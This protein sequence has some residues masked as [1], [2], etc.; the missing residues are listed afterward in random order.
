MNSSFYFIP[1]YRLLIFYPLIVYCFHG[2]PIQQNT[3]LYGNSIL[4]VGVLFFLILLNSICQ[5]LNYICVHVWYWL[6]NV[7][8][9]TQIKTPRHDKIC[10]SVAAVIINTKIR[11]S[12]N[13]W[14]TTITTTN[15]NICKIFQWGNWL[16]HFA[17]FRQWLFIVYFNL[18]YCD[19]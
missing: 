12:Y 14:Q 5:I 17:Y 11:N 19:F 16:L 7:Y 4:I 10:P 9:H 2:I 8:R 13:K 3:M 18:R 6:Y 1:D 15:H